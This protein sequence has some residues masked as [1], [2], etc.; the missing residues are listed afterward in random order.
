MSTQGHRARKRFGQNFLT[1]THIIEKIVSSIAPKIDQQ[2]IEIGPGQGALTTELL[3]ANPNL[4]AIEI[5][6]DLAAQLNMR[7]AHYPQFKLITG[8]ALTANYREFSDAGKPLRLIGN[9]P[10]NLSTPLLFHLLDFGDLISDMHF[11][12]QKEVV[13]RLAANPGSKTYGR[14]SVMVQYRCAVQPLFQVPPTAFHPVPKVE[15]MIVRLIPHAQP[16]LVADHF[17]S[18]KHLVNICFQQRRKTLRNCL[19]SLLPVEQLDTLDIPLN[20]RPDTLSVNDFVTLSNR[21]H[22]L[23]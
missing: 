14:L 6:R 11:M 16:A 1:D 20:V 17:P 15:S 5:D 22:S 18:F 21:I 4:T 13:D 9:L 2:L 23:L 12:L 10:Y 19:K 8:D 7:F 3:A